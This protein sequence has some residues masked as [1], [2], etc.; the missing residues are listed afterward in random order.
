MGGDAGTRRAGQ[1]DAPRFDR[2]L[3]FDVE[4]GATPAPARL[5]EAALRTLE[6]RYRWGPDGLLFTAGWGPSY[7]ERVLRVPSPIP[8]AKGLSE[9]ELPAIDDYD[10]CLHFACDDERRLADVEAALGHGKPLPGADGLVLGALR[11]R[12]TRTGFV[13]AGLPA[14]H[15][16][17]GGIPP[18]TRWPIPRHCSW[19]S[20]P[21]SRRT[22]R[23]RTP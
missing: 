4:G 19:A 6:R 12:E 23:P 21:T 20:S 11:W 5:L 10:L 14:A 13:G 16:R 9:F 18:G 2:L 3:F 7:F 8:R 17:V 15:Q 22:R 1:P